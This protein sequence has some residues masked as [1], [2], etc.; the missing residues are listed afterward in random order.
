MSGVYNYV[1]TSGVIVPNTADLKTQVD[2]EFKT[3]FN[4]T[5]LNT[6]SSTPQGVL[7]AG[8]VAARAGVTQNNAAVANQINPNL[9]AGVFL[10]AICA[11]TGLNRNSEQF[12]TVSIN[13]AGVASSPIPSGSEIQSPLGDNF[14]LVANVTLDPL[15]GDATVIYQA[16]A[17]GAVPAPTGTY[18]IVTAVL[19]LETAV[20]VTAGTIGVAGQSDAELSLLRANTLALQGIAGIE[21]I[22][23]RVNETAGV[24]GSQ[25]LENVTSVDATIE[26][27]FLKAHSVWICA[28]GGTD[29]DVATSLL[30]TKSQGSNWNGATNVTVTDAAS[31][32][33]YTV[34]FD[35]PT[36]V[37]LLIRATISQRSFVGNLV[38]SV[39]NAILAF[40]ANQLFPDLQGFVVGE[41]AS[42][43]EV[44]SAITSQCKGVYV[45]K[46]ELAL[47][48]VG[49][50]APAEIAMAIFQKATVTGSEISLV[51]I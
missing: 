4:D 38:Q 32:Q 33:A 41:S 49:T 20:C 7:I 43:F 14:A 18:S 29:V 31:G 8:E 3:A 23:S 5:G 12:S 37:P 26:A 28:D 11:L 17:S 25:I 9:A 34:K 45:Q 16:V 6:D 46:V 15:T 2:T 42:P 40:A 19:G 21:A 50:Y 47:V 51:V 48:S 27:V 22:A 35:R 24:I 1:T 10:D 36:L 30:A 13:I 44:A 39:T